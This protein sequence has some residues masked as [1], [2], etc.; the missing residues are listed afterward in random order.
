[1]NEGG[2]TARVKG[3]IRPQLKPRDRVNRAKGQD[4]ELRAGVRT[5]ASDTDGGGKCV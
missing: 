2:V 5:V 4:T 1:M 3:R